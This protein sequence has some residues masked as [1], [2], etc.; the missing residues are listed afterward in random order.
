M[1]DMHDSG[2]VGWGDREVGLCGFALLVGGCL[3][4]G[5]P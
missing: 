2:V 3:W 5:V 4:F 1:Q